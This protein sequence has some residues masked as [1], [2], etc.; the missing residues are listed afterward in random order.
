VNLEWF[1]HKNNII[2]KYIGNYLIAKI[3]VMSQEELV[4]RLLSS[5]PELNESLTKIRKT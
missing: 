2:K 3:N 5:I 1:A 4:N